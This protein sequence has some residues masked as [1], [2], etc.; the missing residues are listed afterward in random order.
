MAVAVRVARV[1]KLTQI[2]LPRAFLER[3]GFIQAIQAAIRVPTD[4]GLLDV[5]RQLAPNYDW[6]RA[7]AAPVRYEPPRWIGYW[8]CGDNVWASEGVLK[9]MA[10]QASELLSLF[11]AVKRTHFADRAQPPFVSMDHRD[12]THMLAHDTILEQLYVAA[13][14]QGEALLVRQARPLV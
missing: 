8:K 9:I 7:R 12:P 14:E 4:P 1:V 2:S 3:L 5:F 10:P 11:D 13:F 6:D